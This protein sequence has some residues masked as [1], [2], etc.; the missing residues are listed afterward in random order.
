MSFTAEA[1]E[2]KTLFFFTGGDVECRRLWRNPTAVAFV[3]D[4]RT[5]QTTTSMLPD[6]S[7]SAQPEM[8]LFHA[9]SQSTPTSLSLS[10]FHASFAAMLVR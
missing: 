3:S 7:R 10:G 4:C 8:F 5:L 9:V 1:E 2:V 6:F